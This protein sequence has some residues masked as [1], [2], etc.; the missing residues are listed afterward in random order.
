LQTLVDDCYKQF[1]DDVAQGRGISAADVRANY[2]EG[3][4]LTATDAKVAGMVDRIA[5]LDETIG[6]LTGRKAELPSP[7]PS[8]KGEGNSSSN[9]QARIALMRRRLEIAQKQ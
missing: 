7:Q 2:G 5:G 8:P 4:V 3:R 6:R 1:V 9:S